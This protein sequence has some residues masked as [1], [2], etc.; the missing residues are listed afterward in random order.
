MMSLKA[1]LGEEV[2]DASVKGS[3]RV[4]PLTAKVR[5]PP[6]S[7]STL[8]AT[9]ER[10][11]MA[12]TLAKRA[13]PKVMSLVTIATSAMAT[14]PRMKGPKSIP[15]PRVTGITVMSRPNSMKERGTH[16]E[17]ALPNIQMT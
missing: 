5:T 12:A 14:T 16:M 17:S 7:N 9:T 15:V 3:C 10:P 6:T 4:M 8:R 13:L 2:S 11:P 1:A